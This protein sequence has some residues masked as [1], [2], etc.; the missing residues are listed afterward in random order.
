MAY[1]A[2]GL[3][4]ALAVAGAVALPLH[5]HHTDDVPLRG[6]IG[7]GLIRREVRAASPAQWPSAT[8]DGPRSALRPGSRAASAAL[9]DPGNWQ[10][11][12]L[13]ASNESLAPLGFQGMFGFAVIVYV[14]LGG[15]PAAT[16]ETMLKVKSGIVL[17]VH[18]VMEDYVRR[19]MSSADH[20]R[21]T[22]TPGDYEVRIASQG[23]AL[24]LPCDKEPCGGFEQLALGGVEARPS[25]AGVGF[26]PF[27]RSAVLLVTIG[28]KTE[29]D[30]NHILSCFDRDAGA[31]NDEVKQTVVRDGGGALTAFGMDPRRVVVQADHIVRG[32]RGSSSASQFSPTSVVVLYRV[33][34]VDLRRGWTGSTD[35]SR[36]AYAGAIE[37]AFKAGARLNGQTKIAFE[38]HPEEGAVTTMVMCVFSRQ[39]LAEAAV[40][41]LRLWK[42]DQEARITGSIQAALRTCGGTQVPVQVFS[43]DPQLSAMGT[44]S[45]YHPERF[46]FDVTASWEIE[47]ISP[48]DLDLDEGG[49]RQRGV[50][51]MVEAAVESV[52]G[53]LRGLGLSHS[54]SGTTD[55]RWLR[56][57]TALEIDYG[58]T[59]QDRAQAGSIATWMRGQGDRIASEL[60]KRLRAKSPLGGMFS[61][62]RPSV[63]FVGVS[64]PTRHEQ[65][66]G[67]EDVEVEWLAV[68][69]VEV[70]NISWADLTSAGSLWVRFDDAV[71]GAIR[72]EIGEIPNARQGRHWERPGNHSVQV[73]VD[74]QLGRGLVARRRGVTLKSML[75]R[76]E[77]QLCG[78][79]GEYVR[80][81][82]V[83]DM[84]IVDI[85]LGHPHARFYGPP[86]V[87][88]RDGPPD[89]A[90]EPM[91]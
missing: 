11:D 14:S 65:G 59:L 62:Q 86:A 50:R 51:A 6:G 61:Q 64:T 37:A 17:D 74:W 34:G 35:C 66:E 76:R 75:E 56:N 53:D 26:E 18:G 60:L 49:H 19:W 46:P 45:Q 4:V 91:V 63:H 36:N 72:D 38:H 2:V 15:I 13:N 43:Q 68:L 41:T 22:Q 42:R 83:H 20:L 85:V 48:V 79:I 71:I 39:P 88:Q 24:G 69:M 16:F 52:A 25:S 5:A 90:L 77:A 1:G 9:M 73:K 87:V 89:S 40:E 28:V 44:D 54:M 55:S 82:V 80:Q 81:E 29:D 58:V 70:R 78:R 10:V 31:I 21:T 84:R 23:G 67:Y 27:Q 3:C 33:E 30:G 12:G 32:V 47:P 7:T 57:H 8:D